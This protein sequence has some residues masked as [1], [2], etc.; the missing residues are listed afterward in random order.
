MNN[1]SFVCNEERQEL[2][3]VECGRLLK[4]LL[5]IMLVAEKNKK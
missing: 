5:P 3:T 2:Q 1:D 4:S